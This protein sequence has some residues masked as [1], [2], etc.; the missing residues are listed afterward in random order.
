VL[1]LTCAPSEHS[2][3]LWLPV[4]ATH[5]PSASTTIDAPQEPYKIQ[6]DYDD[7]AMQVDDTKDRVYIHNLDEEIANIEAEEGA[8]KLVFLPDIEKKLKGLTDRVL[9]GAEV[10]PRVQGNE[11]V[12]YN[13]P[14]SLSVPVEHDSVRKAILESR[15]R[16]RDSQQQA[17]RDAMLHDAQGSND[18]VMETETPAGKADDKEE[19]DAMDI[20]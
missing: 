3:K 18:D 5:Q 19:Y 11:L 17:S 12:L 4:C 8:D 20:G 16:T 14:V 6:R 2:G 15:A 10:A 1:S 13:I 9:N 7:D